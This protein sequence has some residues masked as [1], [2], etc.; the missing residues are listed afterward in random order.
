MEEE[1]CVGVNC[2]EYVIFKFGDETAF[3]DW[4]LFCEIREKNLIKQ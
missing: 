3:N 4:F 1:K 2:Y